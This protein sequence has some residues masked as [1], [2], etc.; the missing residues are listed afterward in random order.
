MRI[1]GTN[2]G[3]AA[4]ETRHSLP[5]DK[6]CIRRRSFGLN[7]SQY[8]LNV[9]I[10]LGRS[11][12]GRYHI[13]LLNNE[14]IDWTNLTLSDTVIE[15]STE[16]RQ[17][18]I[19]GVE[20]SIVGSLFVVSESKLVFEPYA[21]QVITPKLV[22]DFKIKEDSDL[23]GVLVYTDPHSNVLAVPSKLPDNSFTVIP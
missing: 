19:M 15:H 11:K 10:P 4:K 3:V 14:T 6:S 23:G 22:G 5:L 17:F 20:S 16:C 8:S 7:R 9:F 21:M 13:L 18:F 12:K 1:A 2:G